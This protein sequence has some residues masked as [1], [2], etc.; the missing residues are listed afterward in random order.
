MLVAP[1]GAGG[2]W[3][4]ESGAHGVRWGRD[5]GRFLPL[6]PVAPGTVRL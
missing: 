4:G 5:L 3:G 1:E 2:A 6:G